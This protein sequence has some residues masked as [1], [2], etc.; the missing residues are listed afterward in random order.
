MANM[1]N[2]YLIESDNHIILNKL[3]EDIVKENN[4]NMDEVIRFD[5]SERNINEVITELD[6]YSLFSTR[7]IVFAYDCVF[8]TTDKTDIEHDIDMFAKYINNPKEDNILIIAC[9]K[10]DGKKNISKLVK[11][12]FK[13]VESNIDYNEYVKDKTKGYKF[14]NSDISY[15]LSCMNEDIDRINNELDK[16]MMLKDSEKEITKSDID[17]IVIKKI[18]DNIFDLIEAIIKKDKKRSLTIYNDIVNYGEEVFKIMISLANQVRLLLQV[19]ILEKENDNDIAERL[20]L[21]NPKQLYFLRQKMSMYSKKELADYLLKLSIMDE[22]LKLGKSID[23]IAFP[24]FIAT[25]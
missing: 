19:K 1:N 3:L 18:D 20:H 2:L 24:I 23:K 4:F 17:L 5:V 25:L 7:K 11:E 14:S 16:L 21:K 10:L 22:E 9:R 8:L 12:K 13:L 15:F 6:T